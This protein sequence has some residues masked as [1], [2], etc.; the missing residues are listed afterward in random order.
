MAGKST[1]TKHTLF[2]CV[3]A[4]LMGRLFLHWYDKSQLVWLAL[5]SLIWLLICR[6]IR[7][8]VASFHNVFLF[9][10]YLWSGFFNPLNSGYL[11]KTFETSAFKFPNTLSTITETVGVPL[12][13]AMAHTTGSAKLF[14]LCFVGLVLWAVRHPVIAVAMIHF[15]G[16]AYSIFIGN[17]FLFYAADALVWF[18][19]LHNILTN[20]IAHWSLPAGGFW[21][22]AGLPSF[23][24]IL[25]LLIVWFNS[26]TTYVPKPSFTGDTLSGFAFLDGKFDPDAAVVATWWD[27]GYAS[28]FLNGL[29]VLHFGGSVN[30]PTTYFVARAILESS[31]ENT[32]GALKF[33]ANHGG[34][35]VNRSAVPKHLKQR[36]QP[37]RTGLRRYPAGFHKTNGGLDGFNLA[38]R[39]LGYRKRRTHWPRRQSGWSSGQLRAVELPSG[40]LSGQT[41]MFR[42]GFRPWTR[43]HQWCTNPCRMGTLKGR[44]CCPQK[45]IRP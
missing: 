33:L 9:I 15:S 35:G 13:K 5:A 26:P 37:P 28:T 43:A 1:T 3:V 19:I 29:P 32:L 7:P 24:V 14:I 16:L 17:R 4:G 21:R 42:H 38:D 41:H 2:W 36:L 18:G 6:R 30:T 27:Y 44:Q 45:E 12:D 11:K 10:D 20:V 22:S 31:Q 40:R 8:L 23:S 25:G 34:Q 39:Q